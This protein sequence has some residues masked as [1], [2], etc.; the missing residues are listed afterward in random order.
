MIIK[1]IDT[2][3]FDENGEPLYLYRD[4]KRYPPEAWEMILRYLK[5]NAEANLLKYEVIA[6]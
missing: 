6:P 3:E 2:Q 4:S 1:E 5:R